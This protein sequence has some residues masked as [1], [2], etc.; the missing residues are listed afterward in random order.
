MKVPIEWLKEYVEIEK[1]P[2]ELAEVLTMAG[3]EVSAIEFHGR[4]IEGVVVGK[5]KAIERH[6]TKSEI[7]VCQVDVGKKIIQVLTDAK[8]LRVGDKVPVAPVGA[9]LA[10]D[11]KVKRME[12]H[13]V[14]SFGMLCKAHELGLAEAEGIMILPPEVMP[15]D[16]VSK[17]LG[18]GGYVFEI[19][20]LPNRPDL[21]SIIGIGRE[22]AAI[23]GK[24]LKLPKVKVTPSKQKIKIKA[25][26]LDFDS[27]P[28]YMARVID[29]VIVAESPSHIKARLI[30]AGLR[31]VNN[32]VD[33]TNYVLMEMGQPLHA[34]DL[35]LISGE[36]IIVRK[37]RA[38]EEIVTL[39][40]VSYKMEEGALLICDGKGPIAV[41]GIMGGG[42]TEVNP[43]TK[44]IL[45][46]GAYFNPTSISQTSKKLKLRTESSIRFERGVNWE[47]VRGALDRTAELLAK[48]SHGKVLAQVIDEKKKV[49]KP[50]VVSLRLEKV[51]SILGT[52]ISA[53]Q[54][55]SILERLTFEKRKIDKGKKIVEIEVPLFR[56]G[57]VEREIDLIEEIARIYGYAKIKST[58]PHISVEA[59]VP[60]IKDKGIGKIRSA[61]SGFGLHE[62]YTFSMVSP[63]SAPQPSL[64]IT[65]PLSEEQSFL[66]TS[67]IPNL[68]TTVSYNLNRGLENVA[69]YEIGKIFLKEKEKLSLGCALI[70]KV[71]QDKDY[72]E[73]KAGFF[74][75]KSIVEAVLDLFNVSQYKILETT[76]PYLEKEV[77]ADIFLKEKIGY[78]G[79]LNPDILKKYDFPARCAAGGKDDVFIAELD[80]ESIFSLER[81]PYA[82]K[83]LP[84]FPKVIRD[85]AIFVP[86]SVTYAEIVEV[87]KKVGGGILEEISIF[88]KYVAPEFPPGV[89]SIALR[90]TY[91]DPQKTLTDPEVNK[92]HD[93]ISKALEEKLKV[94]VRRTK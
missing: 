54:V 64:R 62:V 49:W 69:I 74:Y 29:G 23:T 19:D 43:N 71:A 39:D 7:F 32:V 22:V 1:R 53:S 84:K 82:I 42:R 93:E 37:S 34:F 47:G 72:K 6:P 86:S 80:L 31:P 87:I 38:G 58:M 68:L 46:E 52:D 8:N 28:R 77:G 60:N 21:L 57:D 66:R 26:V 12:L 36:K 88:D 9:T 25:E 85:I 79:A 33:I 30:A 2:E 51:N 35:S 27:C 92:K 50:K 11:I 5:I 14:E 59:G 40:S 15:G 75:I 48:Y 18:L 89:S 4:G 10:A 20:V 24:K 67:L 91:R 81:G 41:A 3:I 76:N 63:D 17:V 56:A 83:P 13:G 65:N 90:I 55:I 78:F 61:L 16:P 44:T 70:G 94:Q 45:L 73:I